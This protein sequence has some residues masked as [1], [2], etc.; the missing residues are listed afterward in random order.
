[1][2]LYEK[3]LYTFVQNIQRHAAECRV[4]LVS[5]SNSTKCKLNKY[6][7]RLTKEVSWR[8]S[9]FSFQVIFAENTLHCV[10]ELAWIR[11]HQAGC[12][13]KTPSRSTNKRF[14]GFDDSHRQLLRRRRGLQGA[15]LLQA[16]R[17]PAA[18]YECRREAA[19]AS[20]N[21]VAVAAIAASRAQRARHVCILV[22]RRNRLLVSKLVRRLFSPHLCICSRHFAL[23]SKS[24]T[25]TVWQFLL[26]FHL[27]F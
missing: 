23:N 18:A 1:M 25:L 7:L 12:L 5:L 27:D 17:L 22:Q 21:L 20:R 8:P 26:K 4:L 9:F 24:L 19:G 10:C 16:T 14:S 3:I 15:R 11:S 13:P 2:N 6:A